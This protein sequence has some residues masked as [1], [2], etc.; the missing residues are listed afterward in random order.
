M[1]WSS[2]SMHALSAHFDSKR[3]SSRPRFV[4][5]LKPRES[6]PSSRGPLERFVTGCVNKRFVLTHFHPKRT[7]SIRK[8]A[9]H[10]S[11]RAER[12]CTRMHSNTCWWSPKP[13]GPRGQS[14]VSSK[15]PCTNGIVMVSLFVLLVVQGKHTRNCRNQ[16]PQIQR[17]IRLSFGESNS[18][19]TDNN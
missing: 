3:K 12:D 5:A 4:C 1:A 6:N 2:P 17:E 18:G 8:C 9:D 10:R 15:L 16:C 13:S 19:H 11:D 14:S 7:G